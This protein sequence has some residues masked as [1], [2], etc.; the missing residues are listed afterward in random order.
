MKSLDDPVHHALVYKSGA[1]TADIQRTGTAA[2]N[3]SMADQCAA[4]IA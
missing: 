1:K 3:Y 4:S 2:A